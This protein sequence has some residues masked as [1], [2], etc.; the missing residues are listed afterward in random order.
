MSAPAAPRVVE[1]AG[2]PVGGA[3]P[4]ALIAGPCQ[5]ES[6]DH[7]RM[8]AERILS[9]L[10]PTGTRLIFK[11]SYDKANR[12][13]L[14]TQRGLGME[15][16]LEILD[17]IRDEF[18]VPGADRRARTRALRPGGRDL[19]GAADPRLPVAA[20]PTCCSPPAPRAGR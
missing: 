10:A 9:A 11:A 7:A 14:G 6:L 19:R 20:R 4:F 5:L 1:I 12:S 17:R 16:G 3:N 15:K 13:S 2:I 18:G 8:M